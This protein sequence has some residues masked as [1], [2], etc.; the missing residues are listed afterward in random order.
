[1]VDKKKYSRKPYVSEMF[2]SLFG[3]KLTMFCNCDKEAF[4]KLYNEKIGGVIPGGIE[5]QEGGIEIY[6]PNDLYRRGDISGYVFAIE[7]TSG[8]ISYVLWLV[9]TDI[10]TI[11]HEVIHLT[12]RILRDVNIFLGNETE[13]VF[14]YY[15]EYWLYMILEEIKKQEEKNGY[16]KK[17]KTKKKSHK[18][19]KS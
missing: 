8:T 9:N 17:D 12:Y 5:Q 11:T 2:C 3:A 14:A 1:M 13:E 15:F 10:F 7:D 16:K 19:N 18:K 4:E 6:P